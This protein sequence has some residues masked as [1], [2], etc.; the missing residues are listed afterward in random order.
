LPA[1][2]QRAIGIRRVHTDDQKDHGPAEVVDEE[3]PRTGGH[4]TNRLYHQFPGL[5]ILARQVLL[6]FGL[7]DGPFL[8]VEIHP[9]LAAERDVAKQARGGRVLAFFDIARGLLARSDAFEEVRPM[10]AVGVSG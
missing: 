6:C 3:H 8:R 7:S 5:S 1:S 10:L 9:E 4:Y 2:A